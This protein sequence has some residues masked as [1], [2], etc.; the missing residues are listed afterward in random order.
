MEACFLLRLI[1]WG[2]FLFLYYSLGR[3]ASYTGPLHEGSSDV[4][5]LE[6][7]P[8]LVLDLLFPNIILSALPF[9]E[10]LNASHSSMISHTRLLLIKELTLW[11][12]NATGRCPWD[13]PLLCNL[14][15]AEAWSVED[16]LIILA[17]I[18]HLVRV[19]YHP[20]GCS[21]CSELVINTVCVSVYWILIQTNWLLGNSHETMREIWTP[22]G[23]FISGIAVYVGQWY[24]VYSYKKFIL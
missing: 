18:H 1:E 22:T 7:I 16:S 21:I 8:I 12:K 17:K 9:W 6:E 3:S 10:L 2:D 20:E 23:Y 14:S 4:S 15:P 24:S 19:M 11:Q 5:S 13:S